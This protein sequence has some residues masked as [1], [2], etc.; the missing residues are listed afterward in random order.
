MSQLGRCFLR[1][2]T[3]PFLPSPPPAAGERP[4]EELPVLAAARLKTQYCDVRA[5]Q[6]HDPFPHRVRLL[7]Y[8][9]AKDQ[10]PPDGSGEDGVAPAVH[11]L[12]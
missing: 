6:N 3:R 4:R 2:M 1:Y 8:N 5:L 7:R 10:T 12:A 11:R 9:G